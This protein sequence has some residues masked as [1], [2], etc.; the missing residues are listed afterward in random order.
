MSARGRSSKRWLTPFDLHVTPSVSLRC[1]QCY[2]RDPHAAATCVD[3]NQCVGCK[4]G[5]VSRRRVDGVEEDATIQHERVASMA[6][7]RTRRFSTNA[8]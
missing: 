5:H 3:I 7:R 4:H 2:A 8:P 1:Q 6:L